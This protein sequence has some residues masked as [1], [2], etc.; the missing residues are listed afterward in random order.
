MLFLGFVDGGGEEWVG[1]FGGIFW[2][3]ELRY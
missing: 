1:Q 2:S 3:G